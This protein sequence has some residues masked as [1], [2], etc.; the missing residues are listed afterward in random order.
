MPDF[1]RAAPA[2]APVKPRD[3]DVTRPAAARAYDFYLGG[4]SNFEADRE[5]GRK[6]LEQVPFVGAFARNN[7]AFLR[8]AVAWLCERGITQFLDI[9]SGIPTVGN[10]HE[11]AQA[12][13]PRARTIY[14]DY[15]PVAVAHSNTILD[16]IDPQRERTNVVQ[17]DLRSPT[18]ILENPV[19]R[20]LIDF[21]EPVGLLVVATMHFIGPGDHPGELIARYRDALTAGSHL[22]LSHLTLDGVPERMQEQGRALETLYASTPNPGYFR[23]RAEFSALFDGLELLEPGI[24]WAPEWHPDQARPFDE[25]ATT[26]TLA[27]VGVKR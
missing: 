19:T 22:V 7:R 8:R 23:D 15:E 6:V 4:R 25:P 10:V 14:V 27:G 11:I 13:N 21:T 17:A 18:D 5:F 16:E 3:V 20:E 9:G 2:S 1:P 24:V 26:A 12:V